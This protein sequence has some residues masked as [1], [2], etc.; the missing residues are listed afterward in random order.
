MTKTWLSL[1]IVVG[2]VCMLAAPVLAGFQEGLDA[3]NRG[4]YD[5]ALKEMR[6]LAEQGVAAA[7]HNL[8]VMYRMGH[9]VPQD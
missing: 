3:Y 4:D 5:T 9:G 1:S 8:G 6:P 2:L 7:Q